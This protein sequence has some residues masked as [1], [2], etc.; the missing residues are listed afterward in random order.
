[1]EIESANALLAMGVGYMCSLPV[2]GILSDRIVRSR[3]WV[4]LAALAGFCMACVV[5]ELWGAVMSSWGIVAALFALGAF[6][7]PGQIM[8]AHI[9]ELVSPEFTSQALTAVNL[10]TVLGAAAMTQLIG[11]VIPSQPSSLN[12]SL[13]FSPMWSV[14]IVA[15]GLACASYLVVPES[16]LF[17]KS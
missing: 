15:L 17:K 3:K 12:A 8:Y 9:K 13:N 1:G 6:A 7:G 2:S 4:V 11:L 14:G 5:M 16:R 10:F